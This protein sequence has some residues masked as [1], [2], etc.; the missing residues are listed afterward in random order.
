MGLQQTLK[1][2]PERVQSTECKGSLQNGRK[3]LQIKPDKGCI[4]YFHHVHPPLHLFR[5]PFS[6]LM[7]PIPKQNMFT[8]L[9]W[10]F[11]YYIYISKRDRT[12]NDT[13][14]GL[15]ENIRIFCFPSRQFHLSLFCSHDTKSF[16]VMALS[17]HLQSSYRKEKKKRKS[18]LPI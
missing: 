12:V 4:K 1:T 11:L 10:Y 3:Y 13:N 6:F 7:L 9:W 17:S 2:M 15:T 5:L 8:F 16:H 18:I 14:T